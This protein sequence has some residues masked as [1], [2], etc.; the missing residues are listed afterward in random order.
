MFHFVLDQ[1]SKMCDEA[2]SND[3]FK[4]K[5]YLDRY[6]TPE[7]C[8]KALDDFLPALKFVLDW[9]VKRKMIKKLHNALLADDSVLFF[10]EFY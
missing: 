2:V 3:H 1:D 8:D 4:L 9:F 10:D 5:H 6:K 7:M